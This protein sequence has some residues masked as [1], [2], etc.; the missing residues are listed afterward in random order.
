M[1]HPNPRVNLPSLFGLWVL[2][3][4]TLW[5][6]SNIY[7]GTTKNVWSERI[8]ERL[9]V[10]TIATGRNVLYN[11]SSPLLRSVWNWN[12]P[13]GIEMTDGCTK[14]HDFIL[15]TIQ[16]DVRPSVFDCL[17]LAVFV[18]ISLPCLRLDDWQWSSVTKL[19]TDKKYFCPQ[20][21]VHCHLKKV[22]SCHTAPMASSINFIVF[23][24]WRHKSTTTTAKKIIW[25][26]VH[27]LKSRAICVSISLHDC[28][29]ISFSITIDLHRDNWGQRW[30]QF[31]LVSWKIT[32]AFIKIKLQFNHLISFLKS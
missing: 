27:I 23:Q 21:S 17:G 22:Y 2:V 28:H 31:I 1:A 26:T 9:Y 12:G 29:F 20:L 30:G 11:S 14:S 6:I 4:Y 13:D 32:M 5:L 10:W 24:V 25:M 19:Q 8:N 7:N 16:R 15:S 3:A 18:S